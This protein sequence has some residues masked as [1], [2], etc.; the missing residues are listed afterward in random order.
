MHV[1]FRFAYKRAGVAALALCGFSAPAF[2][3]DPPVA[4]VGAAVIP[5]DRPGVLADHTVLVE[6]RTIAVIG[7][8]ARTPVPDG[9][10]VIDAS[11]HYLM[12]GLAEM[13][14]HI[15]S[16]GAGDSYRD[17]VLVLFIA[18]GVTT[19]RG[20]L[21]EASHLNLRRQLSDGEIIGPRL[22]TSGPSFNGRSVSG[23]EQAVRMVDQQV[24]AGYD[25]LK[26][27]PG[28]ELDEFEAVARAANASGIPFA[29]HVS[30]AVGIQATLRAGQ[31]SIDHLDG[32]LRALAGTDRSQFFGF[33]L[34]Q[35]T[36]LADFA[37]LSR[38]TA[39]AGVWNVP[40]QALIENRMLTPGAALALPGIEY[41]PA[42]VVRRWT[43]SLRRLQAADD[44]SPQAASRFIEMRR[45]LIASL[46][47][48][49]AGILLGSDSPQVFNV[50]GF[51]TQ[52]EL[53]ILVEAG[54]TPADA[55]AAGTVNPA[56][57]FGQAQRFGALRAGLEAD[58]VMLRANPLEDIAH[59]SGIEGVMVR[60]DWFDRRRLDALL[61]RLRESE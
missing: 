52:Q 20:M 44:Y 37:E 22:F 9:A 33:D 49:G 50:P 31:A 16:A 46:H 4:F 17:R 39:Q 47:E 21:G 7:P 34:A 2:A 12:P 41:M 26:L 48:H 18:N 61:A 45:G 53:R 54:L 1:L 25:F 51:A 28:L 60:G 40:T 5:V 58:I 13:H 29:G 55:L 35:R 19:V 3:A 14:A 27:H 56:R 57:F 43:T 42:E 59:A 23:P 30:N 36:D 11:G 38:A 32:Y 6:G 24:R 10:R 15:P 8:S